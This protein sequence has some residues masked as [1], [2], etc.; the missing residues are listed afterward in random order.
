MANMYVKAKTR[1]T[2]KDIVQ[3]LHTYSSLRNDT[4]IYFIYSSPNSTPI[5]PEKIGKSYY[6]FFQF[7]LMTGEKEI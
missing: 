3:K 5:P 7:N 2:C 6:S 1:D 4:E